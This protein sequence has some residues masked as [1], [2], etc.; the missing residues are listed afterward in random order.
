MADDRV[1]AANM[2]PGDLKGC[3]SVSFLEVAV[4]SGGGEGGTGRPG[5]CQ[6]ASSSCLK[7]IELDQSNDLFSSASRCETSN[8]ISG[9]S[10]ILPLPEGVSPISP[11]LSLLGAAFSIWP[12]SLGATKSASLQGQV[13][14]CVSSGAAAPGSLFP[15][16]HDFVAIL[17]ACRRSKGAEEVWVV[18]GGSG[19]GFPDMLDASE[20]EGSG[21]L[22]F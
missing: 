12:K 10:N 18:G 9:M 15:T 11:I 6:S 5:S 20:M 16:V 17:V 21:V 22:S 13:T 3:L 4:G 19:S 14:G 8:G 1:R 2:S 7:S